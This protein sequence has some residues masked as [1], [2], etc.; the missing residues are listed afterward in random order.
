MADEGRALPC[1]WCQ[2]PVRY[3]EV[4]ER[5]VDDAEVGCIS[6]ND[7]RPRT[8]DE[9]RDELGEQ[10]HRELIADNVRR[11]TRRV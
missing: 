1:K 10:A 4:T 6:P 7:H 9:V 2:H 3:N 11:N 8:Y 5:W